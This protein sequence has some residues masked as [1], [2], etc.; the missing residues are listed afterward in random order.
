MSISDYTANVSLAAI[1]AALDG[2]NLY[3]FAGPVPADADDALNMGASHTQI[4]KFTESNDGTTGLT[5]NAPAG[6][7]MA[8]AP[9]EAWEALVA[10]DGAED[11]DTTL[12]PT[13]WRFC[14]SG[15][16]GR[17]AAAG[18]RLQGTAGG[19]T[20]DLPCADQTDNGTNTVSVGTFAVVIDAA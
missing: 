17:G 6:A 18:P 7:G 8:K 11:G 13:F 2:G 9:A 20:T 4:A 12:A 16:N 3:L 19:P 1:K 14:A 10:F 5:F 15:D